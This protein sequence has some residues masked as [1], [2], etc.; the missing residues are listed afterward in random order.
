MSGLNA[1]DFARELEDLMRRRQVDVYMYVESLKMGYDKAWVDANIKEE[2]EY[3]LENDKLIVIG[4]RRALSIPSRSIYKGAPIFTIYIVL[5]KN[6][7]ISTSR[8][9]TS[10]SD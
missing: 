10:Y 9:Y 8:F 5:D 2:P 3:T 1:E 7:V 6:I 4:K